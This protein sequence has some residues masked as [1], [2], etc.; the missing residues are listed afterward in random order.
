MGQRDLTTNEEAGEILSM[1]DGKRAPKPRN[2]GDL[3]LE[4]NWE[5]SPS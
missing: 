1:R 2:V 5:T 4:R 3:Y